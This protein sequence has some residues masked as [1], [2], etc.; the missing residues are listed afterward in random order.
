[1]DKTENSESLRC[2]TMFLLCLYESTAGLQTIRIHHG[3]ATNAPDASKIQYG[4]PT[5]AP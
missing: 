2:L 3:G 4:A 5:V 1:M